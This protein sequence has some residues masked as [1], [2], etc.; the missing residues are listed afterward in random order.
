MTSQVENITGKNFDAPDETWRPFEKVYG[1][2]IPKKD[3]PPRPGDVAGAYA[4]ADTAR[5]LLGWEARLSLEQAIA[6]A[7]KWAQVRESVLEPRR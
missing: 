6:D 7:L 1:R 3:S 4:N 5:V 2:P